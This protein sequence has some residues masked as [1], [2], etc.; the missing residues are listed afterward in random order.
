MDIAKILNIK[1]IFE[2]VFFTSVRVSLVCCM[3]NVFEDIY[4]TDENL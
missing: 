2:I 4:F 1:T 3:F